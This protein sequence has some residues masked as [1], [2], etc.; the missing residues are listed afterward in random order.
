MLKVKALFM[1]M[2]LL[3]AAMMLGTPNTWSQESGYEQWLANSEALYEPGVDENHR[4]NQLE[5]NNFVSS[6]GRGGDAMPGM[7]FPNYSVLDVNGKAY[8]LYETTQGQGQFV[9]MLT[10][11]G[12]T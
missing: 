6:T 11:S 3:G 9:I 5:E 7:F 8:D 12:F 1:V 2:L 10:G 4:I